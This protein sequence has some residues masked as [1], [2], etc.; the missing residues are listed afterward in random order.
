[1]VPSIVPTS[2]DTY[3]L[4]DSKCRLPEVME[5]KPHDIIRGC[6]EGFVEEAA[7]VCDVASGVTT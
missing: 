6:G 5:D 3:I 2:G 1:M 4:L 7:V